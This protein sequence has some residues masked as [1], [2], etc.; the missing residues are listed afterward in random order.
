MFIQYYKYH[1]RYHSA[2]IVKDPR[3]TIVYP[4]DEHAMITAEHDFYVIG[5]FDGIKVE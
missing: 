2:Y 3:L 1:K 5:T 4:A